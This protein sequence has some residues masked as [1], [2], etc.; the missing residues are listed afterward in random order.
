MTLKQPGSV[1]V[2]PNTLRDQMAP[3]TLR[4]RIAP[5]TP[6][7]N[8]TSTSGAPSAA[9]PKPVTTRRLP[10]WVLAAAIALAVI[11]AA[12]LLNPTP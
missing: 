6:V 11:L 8:R 2:R 10:V 4:P 3:N 12:Y 1:V 9:A 7:G 5:G